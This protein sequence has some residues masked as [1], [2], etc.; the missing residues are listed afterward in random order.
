MH[1]KAEN[2][3]IIERKILI[4]KYLPDSLGEIFFAVTAYTFH[5]TNLKGVIVITIREEKLRG[6]NALTAAPR[7]LG[8]REVE[9]SRKK[10]GRNIM[11]STKKKSFMRRFFEN[12][13]D[14]VVKI[15]I[16]A[17]I[18]NLI[19]MF[20]SANWVESAGIAISILLATFISTASEHGSEAAF[21]RL[22]REGGQTLCRVIRDGEVRE[23][24]ISDVVV[25]DILVIGA[26]ERISADG[27]LV[28]GEITTD[29]SS[30]TGESLEIKKRARRAGDRDDFSPSSPYY[31][32]RGCTVISGSGLIRVSRVGDSTMLGG[33][34]QEIQTDTRSSPLKIRLEKLARQ[35]SVLGYILSA[36]VALAYL[37][38]VFVI[39]S[40]FD[41]EI[42]KYKLANLPYLFSHL[43]HA[44][45]LA[46]TVIVVAVPE[47]LPMMIA[48]VL[49][50][51]IKRMVKDNVLVRKPVGIEA[52]GSMN[53]LFTDKTGTLTEGRLSVG[54]IYLGDGS[55][56]S[57]AREIKGNTRA[58]EGYILSAYANTSSLLGRN[59]QGKRDALGGNSTDRAL[60]L[61][62]MEISRSPSDVTVIDKQEFDSIKKY[63]SALVDLNRGKR[64]LVKGAPERILP[65]VSGYIAQD[66]SVK[67]ISRGR[68]ADICSNL[69]S[70]GKR[71]M[72]IA[73]GDGNGLASCRSTGALEGLT[74][75]CLVYLEDKIRASARRSVERLTRAGIGV[76]MIT[77]DNR[78]TAISIAQ[79]CG[80]MSRERSVVLTGDELALKSD[81]ELKTILPHLSVVARALPND[82]SR[83]VRI[84]QELEMVVG[85]TGDGIN[86]AP[87]LKRADVGFAMGSGT[88][89]AK[90]AGDIIIID[91]DLASIVKAVLYGRTV[92]KS[93]RKFISLQLTMNLSAVGVSVICPF[94]GFEAPVTVVQMLWI[95]II[96][97][98]LGGLAFAGGAP[99]ESY[100]DERPK[101]RDESILCGYMINEILLC[102]GFTI[103]I[104]IAFLKIP[105][106]TSLFRMSEGNICLLTG[107]F[108]LFIFASVFNCFNARTDRL[109]ILAGIAKNKT[110][111]LIMTAVLLV[112]VAFVY[113]GGSVLRTVP[114]TARELA[115]TAAMALLVF[116]LDFIRK[117]L[118]RLLFGKRG[119]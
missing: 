112:Q 53:I 103:A 76:V 91:N 31:C 101:K 25:G 65:L 97:D 48:V 78:E 3:S 94:L 73:E 108:A 92:F 116:P 100:M 68:C 19:F 46:L 35:I 107:F 18:I 59:T 88:Q 87:A 110:F 21:E 81:A 70:R 113:L 15:L 102:G 60:M 22:C 111:T 4:N 39:S 71:V 114:L 98:T 30:M 90:D 95:N 54:G 27:I 50:S 7:G 57:G 1:S 14:P 79:E 75:V 37:F 93:I 61:S 32:L 115:A 5:R 96:M 29:Q 44:L 28:S 74:L 13:G 36:A 17:L 41:T 55:Y 43:Y 52:A 72:A 6:Q 105:E 69:T 23:V 84:S 42:I 86:D 56:F 82:K 58:R 38:N 34:S 10:Y 80:I 16:G 77:G 45:T 47:G 20:K 51:N 33:I 83:L 117:L 24:V 49:S 26:G 99:L 85:M 118:W 62:A 109:N 64:I 40:A 119:Y 89:V 66:G 8:E 106:I 63:S 67:A 11:S 9:E 2:I 12:L 104:C